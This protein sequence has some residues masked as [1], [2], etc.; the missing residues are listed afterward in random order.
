VYESPAR[1]VVLERQR[2]GS[3]DG[4]T[5]AAG[6]VDGERR[7]G[8]HD[9]GRLQPA[10]RHRKGLAP[11]RAR[12]P[13]ARQVELGRRRADVVGAGVDPGLAVEVVQVGDLPVRR[14]LVAT[15]STS[16]PSRDQEI[17]P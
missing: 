6:A 1:N 10:Q 7:A 2:P 12:L 8:A 17:G 3:A 13:F 11:G 4:S 14:P 9:A 5:L 16:A 15:R